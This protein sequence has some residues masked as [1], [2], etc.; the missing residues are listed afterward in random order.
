M[1]KTDLIGSR[2]TR[3]ILTLQ[4]EN[5]IVVVNTFFRAINATEVIVHVV[6]TIH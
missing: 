2:L 4:R 1:L 5:V 3:I 6:T